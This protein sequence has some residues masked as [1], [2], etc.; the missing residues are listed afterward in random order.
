MVHPPEV[1]AGFVCALEAVLEA[2][3]RP[4]GPKW[5]LVAP[6]RTS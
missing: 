5:P 1:D 3:R 4:Y 2:C 6:D